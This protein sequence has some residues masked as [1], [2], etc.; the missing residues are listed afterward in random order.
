MPHANVQDALAEGAALAARRGEFAAATAYGVAPPGASVPPSP[1]PT[2]V[3]AADRTSNPLRPASFAEMIGQEKAV[4][5]MERVVRSALLRD[6][7][8]DHVLLVGPSGTGKST[9][10]HVIA[11]EMGVDVYEVEA[12]V[13][14]E[15]LLLLRE[16][17]NDGDLLRIEEI[18]QQGIMERRGR[19][20]STQPEVLYSVMEDRTLT[21]GTGVLDFPKITIIGTT[22]D[23]GRLPDPFLNRFPLRPRLES[24][25][26]DDI[27]VMAVWNAER[28]GLRITLPAAVQLANASRGVPRQINNYL[29]NAGS[30]VGPDLTVTADVASE[31][32]HDLN[33]VTDDGLTPDMQGMLTFLLTRARREM[34]SGEV[35]YQ[36]SVNTIATAIGKSRDSKAVSLRVEPYL[37]ERGYVQVGNAGR[38]L[39]DQ[40]VERARELLGER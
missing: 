24:Y 39:T 10:S 3:S 25:S 30:L 32:L 6:Q 15:T 22:T 12:P 19:G 23:E 31:V 20:A 37:I 26:T 18:H 9:F 27:A 33:G 28:L 21:S 36:A 13:S 38:L 34:Q 35:R 2:P 7:P 16:V 4:A 40:G 5:M 17:M 1:A 8:L 29:R 11:A 14:H